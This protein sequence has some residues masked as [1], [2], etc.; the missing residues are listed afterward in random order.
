MKLGSKKALQ[1]FDEELNEQNMSLELDE[2]E[3]ESQIN[4]STKCFINGQKDILTLLI[5]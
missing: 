3:K 4:V 2:T 1:A 5:T